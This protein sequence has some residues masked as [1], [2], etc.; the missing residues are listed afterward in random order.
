MESSKVILVTGSRDWTNEETIRNTLI[1]IVSG[2][3]KAICLVHGAARGAD[4]LAASVG[5]SF[6]WKV[7]P[8]PADWDK[9]G[10]AA[11]PIRNSQMLD[12]YKPDIVVAFHDD[13]PNSKGTK[14]CVE[15]ALRKG[16]P[17]LLFNSKGRTTQLGSG[18]GS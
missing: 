6:G 15:K 7:I 13:L 2:M 4:S 12:E 1:L 10:K 5:K 17:V 14:D 16:V 11:G 9:Y 8:V 18:E 3:E